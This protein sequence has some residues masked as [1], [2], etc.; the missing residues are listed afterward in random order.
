MSCN[1]RGGGKT[2][3]MAVKTSPCTTAV[4]NMGKTP[5]VCASH[6]VDKEADAK[7]RLPAMRDERHCLPS[8]ER[9]MLLLSMAVI[10][11]Q[12]ACF[13]ERFQNAASTD[14]RSR[15]QS[16]GGP[17]LCNIPMN[18]IGKA[19][20]CEPFQLRVASDMF[21]SSLTE[22]EYLNE[23]YI[24]DVILNR[25]PSP[26]AVDNDGGKPPALDPDVVRPARCYELGDVNSEKDYLYRAAIL[27]LPQCGEFY[28][29]RERRLGDVGVSKTHVAH[30][31]S[32]LRLQRKVTDDGSVTYAFGSDS[33]VRGFF[34]EYTG[35][36]A[37]RDPASGRE[38]WYHPPNNHSTS[39][40]RTE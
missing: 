13:K 7:K 30:D 36:R 2:T 31:M 1:R 39:R 10:P 34:S 8:K 22:S 33:F 35:H 28:C 3:G 19:Y 16:S 4:L 25:S 18:W 11:E 24:M 5:R 40:S 12:R 9:I 17:H 27:F 23:F 20:E 26:P 32:W 14:D 37:Y 15:P 21:P 38:G 6:I 29:H